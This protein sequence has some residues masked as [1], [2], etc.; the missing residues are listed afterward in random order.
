MSSG[1]ENAYT[2]NQRIRCDIVIAG[3]FRKRQTVAPVH[4]RTGPGL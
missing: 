2:V 4:G 1:A 3:Q